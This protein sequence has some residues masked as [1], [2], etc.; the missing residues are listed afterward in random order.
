MAYPI[1]RKEL[2]HAQLVFL[3]AV[4]LQFTIPNSLRIGN[5]Y[6]IA[7]IELILIA[8]LSISAPKR[9]LTY[10]GFNRTIA[11]MLIAVV[12]LAN[13]SSLILVINGLL[14]HGQVAGKTLIIAAFS[15]F[16]TNIIA[17]GLWYWELDSPGLTGV[18]KHEKA[19][20]FLFPNMT[21][22]LTRIQKWEPTFF[23][24]LYVSITNSVAFSPTDT[25]PLTHFAKLLM[26]SQSLIALLTV[27]LVTARAVNIL[28]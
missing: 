8:C 24:Y 2:R 22:E 27:V 9:H 19:P 23:D 3:L 15:I 17:F 7:A 11:V 10:K 21:D 20:Q 26:S 16:I 4:T 28:G 5:R 14:N 12:S 1:G 18:K 25:M 6:W 13:I